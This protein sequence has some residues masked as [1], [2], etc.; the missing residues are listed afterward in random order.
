MATVGIEEIQRDLPSYLRRV[1]A[2]ETLVIVQ[3]GRPVAELKPFAPG[4]KEELRPAG[5]CTGEFSVPEE[6]DASLPDDIL[7]QF[8]GI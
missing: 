3:Q 4:K 7:R 1:Q 5:L 6:F 2:G 8:E